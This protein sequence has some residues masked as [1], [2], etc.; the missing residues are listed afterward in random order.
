[1]RTDASTK[2]AALPRIAWTLCALAA[3]LSAPAAKAAERF[4]IDPEHTFS[5]FEYL[6]WGLSLQR[7]RFDKNSGEIE[8]DQAAKTGKI[9][10]KIDAASVS[11][12]SELFNQVLRSQNFFDVKTYPEIAFISDKLVFKDEQLAQVEGQLTI[13]EI[14]LPVTI[15][16]THFAC[17]FMLLYMK[18]ACGANG[19]TSISRS[20][21]KLGRYVPF[22]SDDVTLYLS[23]EA[24]SDT[25]PAQ[26]KDQ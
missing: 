13:K 9:A 18:R 20:E 16:I 8:L 4:L 24:I 26:N 15:T 1:M 23:V 5:S 11:T 25:A 22:V 10:I 17:R 14:T 21:F 12:G 19:Y 6:H 7:G 3:L 2:L